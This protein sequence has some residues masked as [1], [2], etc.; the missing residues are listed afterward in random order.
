MSFNFGVLVLYV[1]L[2]GYQFSITDVVPSIRLISTRQVPKLTLKA[3]HKYHL[4]LSH[5]CK[6]P[7]PEP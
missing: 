4:F 5:I 7:R 1:I 3:E 2:A 6:L